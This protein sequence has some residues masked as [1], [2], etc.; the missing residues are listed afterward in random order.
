MTG[1]M[2]VLR[3]IPAD[4]PILY[5]GAAMRATTA[6][7]MPLNTLSTPGLDVYKRQDRLVRTSDGFS[8]SPEAYPVFGFNFTPMYNLNYKLR[9]GVSLDGTFEDVYKRQI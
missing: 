6:G 4:L 9:L 1:K 3:V 2:T 7:R 8:P 5:K